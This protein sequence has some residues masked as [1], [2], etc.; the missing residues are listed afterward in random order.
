MKVSGVEVIKSMKD[1]ARVK[2]E[3]HRCYPGYIRLIWARYQTFPKPSEE[4]CGAG[5]IKKED[6]L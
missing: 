6:V 1:D 4:S 5:M 2:K 3:E